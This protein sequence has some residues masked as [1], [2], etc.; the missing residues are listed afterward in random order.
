M[1]LLIERVGINDEINQL[2]VVCRVDQS[3]VPSPF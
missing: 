3:F 1:E 2:R